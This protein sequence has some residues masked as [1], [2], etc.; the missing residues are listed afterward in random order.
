MQDIDFVVFWVDGSTA[1][2][3][4]QVSRLGYI[5]ILVSRCRNLCSVGASYLFRS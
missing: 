3:F 4:G 1:G 2:G 5:E